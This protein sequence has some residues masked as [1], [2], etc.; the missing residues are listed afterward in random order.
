MEATYYK[1]TM[2]SYM[3]IPCPEEAETESYQY[4]MLEMNRIPGLL[5]CG[6]RHIDGERFLYYD[7]TGRQSMQ[8]L[9]EGR[10]I[11]GAEFFHMIRELDRVSESISAAKRSAPHFGQNREPS[12][13]NVPHLSQY[14]LILPVSGLSRTGL[15]ALP[16]SILLRRSKAACDNKFLI[17][18]YHLCGCEARF[19]F[20]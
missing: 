6:L 7:I 1:D 20:L 19:R 14:I 15:S 10:K 9:Y 4:R 16:A 5:A 13:S 3:I 12:G 17:L 18:S 2:R 11:S 8:S